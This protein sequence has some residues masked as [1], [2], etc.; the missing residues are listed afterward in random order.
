M[1]CGHGPRCR[2]LCRP[3]P[4]LLALVVAVCLFCQTLTPLMTNSFLSAVVNGISPNK[5]S[6]TR[7]GRYKEG[8]FSA[9][10]Q[11]NTKEGFVPA[12]Q[13]KRKHTVLQYF[14]SRTRRAILY[15]PPA[16]SKTERQLCQ[17]ILAKHGYAVTVLENRRLVEDLRH[18]GS[19]R[20]WDLLIC[21]SSTKD[22]DTSCIQ[23]D[24]LHQLELFQKFS[25][26]K[27]KFRNE[28]KQLANV[29][30]ILE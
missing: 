11:R 15:A 24:D 21:L 13:E 2:R 12:K 9:G 16:H 7:Q 30:S 8:D 14:G 17:R 5:Q 28:E 19:I 20:P 1:V 25:I 3:R 10:K 23:R 4:F 6:K 18:E 22:D 26:G 27:I 29:G